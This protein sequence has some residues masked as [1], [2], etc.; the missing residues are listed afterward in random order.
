MNKHLSEDYNRT[1][2]HNMRVLEVKQGDKG[3]WLLGHVDKS[4]RAV[5]MILCLIRLLKKG[6]AP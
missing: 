4:T 3:S 5:L 1:I 6:R 2:Q